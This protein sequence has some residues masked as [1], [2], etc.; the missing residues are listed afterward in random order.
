[1]KK[2]T[3]TLIKGLLITLLLIGIAFTAQAKKGKGKKAN[4]KRNAVAISQLET[5]AESLQDQINNIP[6]GETGPQGPVGPAGATG[7]QGPVGP[8][9]ATGSQ[10]PVGPAG[11]TGPQGPQGATGANGNARRLKGR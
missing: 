5:V 10:G 1:M 9:G 8:A 6:A 7:S 3:N 11:A 4:P 2:F